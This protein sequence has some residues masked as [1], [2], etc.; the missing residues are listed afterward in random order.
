MTKEDIAQVVMD[1]LSDDIDVE[2]IIE[3]DPIKNATKSLIF[4]LNGK[5]VRVDVH[6]G[7]D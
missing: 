5:R 2:D 6:V 3:T 4:K 7:I 1:I